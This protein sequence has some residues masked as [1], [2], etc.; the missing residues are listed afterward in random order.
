VLAAACVPLPLSAE[1]DG[2][3]KEKGSGV[4]R[5]ESLKRTL[6]RDTE[7]ACGRLD[8]GLPLRLWT[9][10]EDLKTAGPVCVMCGLFH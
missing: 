7:V 4:D 3:G 6:E 9:Q 10:G 8:K 2:C 5:V 1:G